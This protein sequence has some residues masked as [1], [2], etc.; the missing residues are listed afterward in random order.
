MPDVLL[1]IDPRRRRGRTDPGATMS[2]VGHLRELRT[3]LLISVAAIVL[4][5]AIGFVWYG[6]GVLGLESLGDWLRQPY[7][8]LP[9]SARASI[10]A[11]GGLP[12]VDLSAVG[13]RDSWPVCEGTPLRGGVRHLGSVLFLTG[14]VLAYVAGQGAALLVDRRQ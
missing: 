1:R 12:G 7:C 10:S 9:A 8:S 5:T 6:H 14:A 4:T 11:D 2:L 13:V 3:R